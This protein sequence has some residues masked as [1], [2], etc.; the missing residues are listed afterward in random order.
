[1][2]KFTVPENTIYICQGSKCSKR[3]SR[4][5]YKNLKHYLKSMGVKNDVELIVTECTDRCKY[6][7]V[8]AAQPAN[9][10]LH[11]YNAKDVVKLVDDLL[12]SK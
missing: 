10:W 2:G 4:E 1:M 12:K 3:G 9:I 6:A 7:P 11:E 8:L 5:L